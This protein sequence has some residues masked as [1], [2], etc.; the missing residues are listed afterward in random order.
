MS[1]LFPSARSEQRGVR[2]PAG[3]VAALDRRGA[4]VLVDS[5]SALRHDTVWSCRTRIAQDVSMMPVDVIRYVGGARQLVEPVPQIV[6]APSSFVAALDWR[7][8]V[9][10]AWLADGNVWGLITQTSGNGAWPTRI[11]LVPN[12]SV[13]VEE[14]AGGRRF[15]VDGERHELWPV[16]DLWHVPA[17]T[18]PGQFLGLSPIAYHRT[19]IGNGLAAEQFSA[20]FFADGGHPSA[21]LAPSTDPGP[22]AARAIKERFLAMTRGNRDLV[23]VPQDTKYIPIQV[24]PQDSQFIDTMRYSAEQICRIYGEDPA[25]HGVSTSSSSITYANRV[26]ADLARFK[27]RQFWVTKLQNALTDLLPRPQVVRLNTSATLMMTARERHELH[28]LRL[29]SRTT[30]INEVRRIEDE[31]PFG[32]EF[33]EPGIPPFG[34][35]PVQS[36]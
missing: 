30:T 25:D 7:Y 5:D 16:G 15:F 8:Q 11:E 18:V 31:Q 17:Y 2:L 21:I 20:D 12:H 1:L 3:F 34:T 22:E 26:D 23:V 6:A 33:N 29:E 19:T 35:P 28:R 13:R 4:G 10:D 27:R 36:A 24:S 9:I 32:P 14:A